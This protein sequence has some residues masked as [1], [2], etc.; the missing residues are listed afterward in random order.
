MFS[1]CF[2]N[3]QTLLSDDGKEKRQNPRHCPVSK[4]KGGEV[5][6]C[7]CVHTILKWKKNKIFS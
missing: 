5:A 6:R 7:A 4:V 2:L 3:G 1:L